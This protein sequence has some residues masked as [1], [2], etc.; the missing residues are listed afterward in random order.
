MRKFLY[1]T[2]VLFFL[3]VCAR[4]PFALATNYITDCERDRFICETTVII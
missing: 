3:P 4:P 2:L 1:L